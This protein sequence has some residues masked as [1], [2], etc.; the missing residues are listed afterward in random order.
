MEMESS[1]PKNSGNL[2]KRMV[3]CINSRVFSSRF[4]AEDIWNNETR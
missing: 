1:T 3:A 4:L 2:V